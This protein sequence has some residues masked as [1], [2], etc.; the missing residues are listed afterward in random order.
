MHRRE[1]GGA[2]AGDVGGQR[3]VGQERRGGVYHYRW[4]YNDTPFRIA[5]KAAN[6][7]VG[8]VFGFPEFRQHARRSQLSLS[9]MQF[10]QTAGPPNLVSCGHLLDFR[11]R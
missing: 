4:R 5:T 11:V 2:G 7:T 8:M 1:D 3:D 6:W 9:T 10:R